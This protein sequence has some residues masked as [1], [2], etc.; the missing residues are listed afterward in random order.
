MQV[1]ETHTH[2]QRH[3]HTCMHT[4]IYID[5]HAYVHG[6]II[7][8]NLSAYKRTHAQPTTL[9]TQSMCVWMSVRVHVRTWLLL[10]VCDCMCVCIYIYMC[11]Y[12]YVY[13]YIYVCIYIYISLSLSLSFGRVIGKK[14]IP[15]CLSLSL[16]PSLPPGH[17]GRSRLLGL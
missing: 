2:T 13:K 1:L 14:R 7:H 4:Y 9:N 12:I 11:V 8:T 10:Y 17:R 5:V 15:S 6:C 16:S 3:T